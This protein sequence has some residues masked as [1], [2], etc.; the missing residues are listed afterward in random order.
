MRSSGLLAWAVV[1]LSSSAW[2]YVRTATKGGVAVQWVESCVTVTPDLR[3]SIDVS[4]Q[5]INATLQRSTDNWNRRTSACGYLV[6]ASQPATRVHDVGSDGQPVLVFRHMAWQRPGGMPYDPAAIGLTTVFFIDTPAKLG[7]GTILDA[8]I[9]LNGVNYTFTTNP[10][11]AKART[12]TTIADLENTLTHELGHVQGL[13]HTCWDHQTDSPPRDET[14]TPIPDCASML[15]AK[16]TTATMFPKTLMPGETSKRNVQDDDVKG[17][18]DAYAATGSAPAC[19]QMLTNPGCA[20]GGPPLASRAPIAGSLLA[21][22]AAWTLARRRR[23]R[24]RTPPVAGSGGGPGSP[25]W[26]L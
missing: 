11:T 4:I 20:A 10:A 21:L 1:A 3:G 2:G 15:S 22:A 5:D 13:A 24:P 9:E 26:P 17:V 18:C 16:I 23:A 8:D 25:L 19:Y 7:D 14:G 12:G 6:L